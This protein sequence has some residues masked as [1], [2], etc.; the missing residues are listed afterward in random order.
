MKN[1]PFVLTGHMVEIPPYW[2]VKKRGILHWDIENK[3][4]SSW[5]GWNSLC[6]NLLHVHSFAIQNGGFCTM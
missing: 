5:T 2:M 1:G 3:G 6:S 4:K